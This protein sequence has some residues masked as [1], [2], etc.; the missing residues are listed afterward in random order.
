M[1]SRA[2]LSRM[3]DF[4]AIQFMILDLLDNLLTF[5]EDP[6]LMGGYLTKQI[7]EL[8]GA[9]IVVLLQCPQEPDRETHALVAIEPERFSTWEH[10][11]E[12]E[13]LARLG[14]GIEQSVLWHGLTAP[15]EAQEIFQRTGF[16]SA[17]LSPLRV[18]QRRVGLLV[19]L[20][21]LDMQRNADTVK[22][23]EILSPVA[24]LV[25]RNALFMESQEREIQAR[26]RKLLESERHFRTLADLAPVGIFQLDAKGR[27]Q[28]V[29]SHWLRI[30]GF[31]GSPL[32]Q[33]PVSMV[34]L[35]D[36][37]R[38]EVLWK[39]TQER[40]EPFNAEFRIL[41]PG[42]ELAWVIGEI[43]A[44]RDEGG[45]ISGFIG[46]L[47]D[48]TEHKQAEVERENLKAQ[49]AQAQR[50]ESVG[51]LAGGVAHDINNTLT[52]ILGNAEILRLRLSAEDPLMAQ[53]MG[54]AQAVDRSRGII[55]QLL[56]FSRKQVIEPKVM[57]INTHIVDT[58]RTLAP[59]IGEDIHLEFTPGRD[60]W[61]VRFDPSQL[62]QVLMNL[63]VNARDAMPHG[64][65]IRI[66]TENLS[67]DGGWAGKPIGSA[68]GP[69][70]RLT[71]ADEGCGMDLETQAQIF[72]PFFSTKEPGKG[73]GLGLST[74]F[75][76]VK[77]NGGFIN[78]YSEPELGATFRIYLPALP[79][80]GKPMPAP[81]EA[82]L[83][84]GMGSILVV[85]DDDVLRELIPVM[86][87]RLGYQVIS[88][89]G[90]AV[91]L[92]LCTDSEQAFDL[93]LT[94]V[95]M[96]G[97]SGRQLR[98]AVMKL[99]PGIRVLYMSGY[100]SD[101]ISAKGVLEAGIHFIQKPFSLKELA[102][103]LATVMGTGA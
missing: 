28:F 43:V 21:L 102:Q 36:R 9:K 88:A 87:E 77:Q 39:P 11:P 78:V 30:T 72:E 76:I 29:N 89:P 50:L 7:R 103:K 46:S 13:A 26:T 16:N 83:V 68:P 5:S 14:S 4:A 101:I 98:D 56:A 64:G 24:A 55:Q 34:F 57:D 75:G 17:I 96:P 92:E 86:I 47:T 37:E 38:V 3:K 35:E 2:H 59:L 18:G 71:V 85:E 70:V 20:H 73:T 81:S 1:N 58:R 62:D 23:L 67:V 41:R 69:Y 84:T 95:I 82:P 63:A 74:V 80:A 19:A 8:V 61:L 33:A 60:L 25:L 32:G 15:P 31:T 44:Y 51:R 52:V 53:A 99:R 100:T 94:D 91:A 6:R 90:P 49:L 40:G 42:G 93:L 79:G 10:L 22:I 54:I 48:L 12:L 66:E 27:L 65:R 45:Q 97:M